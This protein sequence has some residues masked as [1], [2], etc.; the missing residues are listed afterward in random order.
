MIVVVKEQACCED[1]NARS[2]S[3]DVGQ[4]FPSWNGKYD[5][6]GRLGMAF[7]TRHDVKSNLLNVIIVRNVIK[8]GAEH[9]ETFEN[10]GA[11]RA[12]RDQ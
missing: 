9:D 1:E 12:H 3:S 4:K 2:I 7:T 5:Q 10:M 11:S 6:L 8:N